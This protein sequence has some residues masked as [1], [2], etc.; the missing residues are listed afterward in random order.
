MRALG[1]FTKAHRAETETSSCEAECKMYGTDAA[2]VESLIPTG[3]IV[4]NMFVVME[5]N[6]SCCSWQ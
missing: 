3:F 5:E 6:I 4:L 2:K 1:F